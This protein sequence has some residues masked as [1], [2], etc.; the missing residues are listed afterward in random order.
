VIEIRLAGPDDVDLLV[1][2]ARAFYDEDGFTTSDTDLARNFAVL[3]EADNAHVALAARRDEVI[4][5][6]LTT[7]A[8]ILES[9]LV[10]ELQDLYVVP[11]ARA[12]GVGT[13]LVEDA[14]R[15]A[16]S[17]SSQLLEVVVAPNGRDVSG[18]I[19]YYRARGFADGGRR[20]LARTLA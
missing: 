18:L 19:A 14:A 16:R 9:G 11:S 6:A 1:P 12:Q 7:T 5:F 3:L 2:L 17:R 15:W 4:G 13:A 8:F 10:A 20:I